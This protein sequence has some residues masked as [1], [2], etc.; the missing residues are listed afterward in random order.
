MR[1]GVA[2][3]EYGRVIRALEDE[4]VSAVTEIM[5]WVS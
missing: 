3:V 1:V 4:V 2:G 5:V